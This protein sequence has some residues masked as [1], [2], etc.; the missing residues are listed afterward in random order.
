MADDQYPDDHGTVEGVRAWV[1]DDVDRARHALALETNEDGPRR[2]TLIS[3]LEDLIADSERPAQ[4][5]PRTADDPSASAADAAAQAAE[6]RA[7]ETTPTTERDEAHRIATSAD[8]PDA[9]AAA[10]ANRNRDVEHLAEADD[11]GLD[12]DDLDPADRRVAE[13]A[14]S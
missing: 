10:A 1:G 9:A 4:Q 5:Q 12:I 6:G 7:D 13:R 2:V 3:W 11:A 14:T 8:D